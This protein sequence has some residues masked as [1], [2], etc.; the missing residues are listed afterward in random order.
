MLIETDRKGAS[1]N[2]WTSWVA[3]KR[4]QV[5]ALHTGDNMRRAIAVL[6][7]VVFLLLAPGLVAGLVPFQLSHWQ[8][9]RP[10]FGL[11]ILRFAGAALIVMGLAGLLE[12]FGR[13]SIQGLGTPAPVLPPRH[14][15]VKGLYRFVRNPMYVAV[16]STIA[17]QALLFGSLKLVLYCAIIWLLFHV[18]VLSYE[19]PTLR[20]TF[21][22]EY[23][24]YCAHVPRWL[25]R[26]SP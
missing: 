25:P 16:L 12:S 10:F 26:L 18:F 6:G 23:D 8:F 11:T 7:S 19:E 4:R 22:G 3:Q 24:A 1:F 14:L 17:G 15:V 2:E 21:G 20:K 13:F 9:E 5:A